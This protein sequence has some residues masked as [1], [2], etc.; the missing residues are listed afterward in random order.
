M[1]LAY[2]AKLDLVV[3]STDIGILKIDG[4][5]LETYEM[6]FVRYSL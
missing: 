4:S 2:A 5:A 6:V 1:T 3:K